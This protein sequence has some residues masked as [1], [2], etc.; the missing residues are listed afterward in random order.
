[1][2]NFLVFSLDKKLN[3][4]PLN[5]N[6]I[7]LNCVNLTESWVCKKHNIEV[8]LDNVCDD[9]MMKKVFSK[10]STCTNCNNY[11]TPDC[12]N[13]IKAAEGLLCFSWTNQA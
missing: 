5:S 4:M 9:H 13:E 6:S 3:V 8:E 12:P 2:F 11:K 1:M 7:C 10:K